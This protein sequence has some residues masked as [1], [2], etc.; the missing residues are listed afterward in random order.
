MN[1]S[2]IKAFLGNKPLINP[3]ENAQSQLREAGLKQAAEGIR[4]NS[5]SS[6][7]KLSSQTTV[8]LRI[9]NNSLNQSLRL[10]DKQANLPA[11]KEAQKGLFDFEEIAKNV[12]RFVSGV[13]SGAAKSG[14]DEAT[15]TDLFDQA[16]SGVAKGIKMAEKELEGFMS[17]E[18]SGGISASAELIERGIQRLQD[19][20]FGNPVQQD[21]A[22]PSSAAVTKTSESVSYAKQE[23]GELNIRTRDGDQVYIQ[24]T[25]VQAFEFNR[26]IVSE[27]ASGPA[28]SKDMESNDVMPREPL[29]T[30]EVPL[31]ESTDSTDVTAADPQVAAQS[32]AE[33]AGRTTSVSQQSMSF[34]QSNLSFTVNGE[35]DEAELASIGQLVSDAN[36][37]AKDFFDGD[38]ETAFNQA[39]ELGFDK[40]ELAGYALQLTRQEQV[41]VVKAYESVSQYDGN[42]SATNASS[43]PVERVSDYL[44]KM[45]N[46]LDQSQQK[47]EDSEQYEKLINSLVNRV[48]DVDTNELVSAI[49]DFHVF[50]KQL[51]NSLPN[52]KQDA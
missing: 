6:V 12:L 11:P 40:Q 3:N 30:D 29:Q 43:K 41:E 31:N 1:F 16:R 35:L 19:E 10:D 32:N 47:L 36:D 34:S 42:E 9:Y 50:N 8:G 4:A 37:L 14:A 7:S 2:E 20:I 33:S 45:L 22:Y 27:Q 48:Q 13:I 44:A 46:V 15:L 39:L 5:E 23:S 26:Q 18:I 17:E 25:G 24:F 21:T 51:L 49:N 38:I 52:Q 28:K